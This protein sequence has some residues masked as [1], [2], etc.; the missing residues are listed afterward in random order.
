LN[1]NKRQHA[2][3]ATARN[4]D[5]RDPSTSDGR[6]NWQRRLD[7]YLARARAS[8]DAGDRIEAE[9]CRQHADHYFRLI[10]G[11]AN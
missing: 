5:S 8:A 3:N 11:T 6:T 2:I 9:N 10:S 4:R 7:S 1:S